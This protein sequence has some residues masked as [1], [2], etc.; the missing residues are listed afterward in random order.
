VEVVWIG[1]FWM[2]LDSGLPLWSC[3]GEFEVYR[4]VGAIVLVN[5]TKEGAWV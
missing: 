4:V 2:K 3:K 1:G 5:D